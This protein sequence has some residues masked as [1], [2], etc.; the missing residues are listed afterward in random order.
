MA[1]MLGAWAVI[2]SVVAEAAE[3]RIQ[4]AILFSEEYNDNIFLLAENR[5]SDYITHVAPALLFTYKAPFWDWDMKFA[6]DYPY[7]ARN[8]VTNNDAYSASLTNQSRIINDVLFLNLR[9]NYER[10]SLDVT[11]DYTQESSVVNQ[12]DRNIFVVNPYFVVKPSKR[13]TVT[14]GYTY[15]N[16]WYKDPAAIDTV[17]RIGSLEINQEVSTRLTMTVGIKRTQNENTLQEYAKDELFLTQRFEFASDSLA[18]VT[19]GN[20]WFDF[21]SLGKASSA[22]WDA[23]IVLRYSATA[24]IFETGRRFIPDPF[25]L[26]RKEDR[27]L[28]TIRRDVERT[29]VVVS[30]GVIDY[31]NVGYNTLETSTHRLNGML[32]HAVTTKSKIIFNLDV[33]HERDH[34]T[35]TTTDRYLSG[36]RFEHLAAEKLTVAL[37]YRYTNVYVP[38]NYYMNYYNNR[39]TVELRKI[40]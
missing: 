1:F 8:S 33:Q 10:V 34:Q 36:V 39:Y 20:G 23:N 31:R 7:Y 15:I 24:V 18:T 27:Y 19:I 11:R 35:G 29:S 5:L 4:T 25:T 12:S 16:T 21:P 14:T 3:Y 40:F 13:T 2:F 22:F 38:E 9:D 17:D 26:L 37:D 30:G 32:S 28:V 6:Y